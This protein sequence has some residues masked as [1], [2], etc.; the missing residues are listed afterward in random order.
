MLHVRIKGQRAFVKGETSRSSLESREIIDERLKI[1]G[2]IIRATR[3]TRGK[4]CGAHTMNNVP[5]FSEPRT[6]S[7]RLTDC[8]LSLY[9]MR[10]VLDEIHLNRSFTFC[11][12]ALNSSEHNF[13]LFTPAINI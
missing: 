8:N 11:A 7:L 12:G 5:R 13:G 1:T 10:D 3:C 4:I 6:I 9:V 2:Q